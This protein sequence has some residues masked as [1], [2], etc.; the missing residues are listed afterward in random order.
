MTICRRWLALAL[1][2]LGC[3]GGSH[4]NPDAPRCDSGTLDCSTREIAEAICADEDECTVCEQASN[5][6]GKIVKWAAMV[7]DCRCPPIERAR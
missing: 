6:Q 3:A 5:T 1:I 4:A 7:G 2:T